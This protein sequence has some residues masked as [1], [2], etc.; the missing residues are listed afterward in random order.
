MKIGYL[1]GSKRSMS[2]GMSLTEGSPTDYGDSDIVLLGSP[3]IPSPIASIDFT[4]H[5]TPGNSH[6]PLLL[7]YSFLLHFCPFKITP[8]PDI[9][10]SEMKKKDHTGTPE[11]HI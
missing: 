8:Q 2:I 1:D 4:S 6:F 9:T 10:N 7:F 11:H 3:I 5:F